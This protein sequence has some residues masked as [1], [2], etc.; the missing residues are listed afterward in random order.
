MEQAFGTWHY[1]YE[2]TKS[3]QFEVLFWRVGISKDFSNVVFLKL[4]T[5]YEAEWMQKTGFS[6]WKSFLHIYVNVIPS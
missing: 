4:P 5:I 2:L 1:F 6:F 3:F